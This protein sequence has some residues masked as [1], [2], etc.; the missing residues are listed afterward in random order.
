MYR[1]RRHAQVERNIPFVDITNH[2]DGFKKGYAN[3]DN[4]WSAFGQKTIVV[5]PAVAGPVALAVVRQQGY[6]HGVN[7]LCIQRLGRNR[8]GFINAPTIENERSRIIPNEVLHGSRAGNDAGRGPLKPRKF[9]LQNLPD[10]SGIY[11]VFCR[12]GHEGVK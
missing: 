10:K 12:I 1:S 9:R 2:V 4:I 8:I 7:L 11:L 5:A 3:L 6:Q